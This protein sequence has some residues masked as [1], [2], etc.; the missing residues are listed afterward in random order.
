MLW[1]PHLRWP[2]RDAK[3]A[4]A[5]GANQRRSGA[6]GCVEYNTS[7]RISV[8]VFLF[9]DITSIAVMDAASLSRQQ[10]ICVQLRRS[11]YLPDG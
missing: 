3:R 5:L 10:Y 7:A 4:Q 11:E 9:R 6:R 2:P 1:P 8:R